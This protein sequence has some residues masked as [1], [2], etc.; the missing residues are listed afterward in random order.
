MGEIKI[1]SL[2]APLNWVEQINNYFVL[3]KSCTG[4]GIFSLL[5]LKIDEITRA[6]WL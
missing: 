2:S 3:L 6:K 5:K 1:L 4:P